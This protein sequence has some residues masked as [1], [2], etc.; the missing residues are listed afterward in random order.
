M[1]DTTRWGV[2]MACTWWQ[3][4]PSAL[5]EYGTH[6]LCIDERPSPLCCAFRDVAAATV[7]R[8]ANLPAPKAQARARRLP[9]R[10]VDVEWLS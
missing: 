2:C 5:L 10:S 4:E 7:S 8:R 1:N 3:I 6:G 9:S